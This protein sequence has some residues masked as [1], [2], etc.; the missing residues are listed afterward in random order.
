MVS[1]MWVLDTSICGVGE[2]FIMAAFDVNT[3]FGKLLINLL[4]E[5]QR[6]T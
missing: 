1:C 4:K 6:I 2:E 5:I 3:F